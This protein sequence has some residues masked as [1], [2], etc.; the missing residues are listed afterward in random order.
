MRTLI[1]GGAFDPVTIGHRAVFEKALDYAFKN[2]TDGFEAI[3]LISCN[4]EKVYNSSYEDRMEMVRRA[5]AP[6]HKSFRIAEQD[7][8]MYDYITETLKLNIEDAYIVVG[9]DQAMNIANGKWRNSN[10]LMHYANFIVAERGFR[11]YDTLEAL[12]KKV[13]QS[14]PFIRLEL[15]DDSLLTKKVSSTKIRELLELHPF[16]LENH[17]EKFKALGLPDAAANYILSRS[18]YHQ[19]RLQEYRR[20]EEI[21]L[22]K[23]KKNTVKYIREHFDEIYN[24]AG[25]Q[26]LALYKDN[27]IK[28][29]EPANEQT[30]SAVFATAGMAMLKDS[31]MKAYGEP[32]A[33]VDIVAVNQS[34]EVLLVRRKDYPYK[35]YWA[36][37]GGFF[38]V[39]NDPSLESTAA[40]EFSEE[41]G[42]HFCSN[43]FH[44]IKT[45]SCKFDPRMRIVD[46][47]FFVKIDPDEEDMITAGDDAAEA[48]WF[49]IYDLPVLAFHHTK[50]IDDFI[51]SDLNPHKK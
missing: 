27:C 49:P 35:D 4:D 30:G 24:D 41:V 5:F 45:Y 28:V 26:A 1:Y 18:L 43:N 44:Q 2:F 9:M 8:R 10:A 39:E 25:N 38:D 22:E 13:P 42:L 3:V 46:T 15:G 19:H 47:A 21:F 6:L 20:G 31:I 40:R 11:K 34:E 37:P 36:L 48:R 23:Y 12:W 17:P 32:S 7:A 51:K 14:K 33:T 50:I 29:N 16:I